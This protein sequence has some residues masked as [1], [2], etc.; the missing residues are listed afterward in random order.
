MQAN[1]RILLI[2]DDKDHLHLC[3]LILQRIGFEVMSLSQPGRA[4]EVVAAFKPHLIFI[5]HYMHDSTG[6]EITKMIRANPVTSAIPLIYF[7]GCDDIVQKSKQ[8]G[9]D[10]YLSKPFRFAEFIRVAKKYLQ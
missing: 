6:T 3:K 2:D 5:D 10:T 4:V 7:S 9:A 1:K 8:A